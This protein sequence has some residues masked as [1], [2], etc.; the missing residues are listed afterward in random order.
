MTLGAL[1]II[2]AYNFHMKNLLIGKQEKRS[3]VGL[4]GRHSTV[5][6]ANKIISFHNVWMTPLNLWG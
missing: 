6:F 2:I 3:V 1:S 5:F 4:G